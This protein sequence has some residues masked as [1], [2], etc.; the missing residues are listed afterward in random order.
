MKILKVR[1]I[2]IMSWMLR[3]A[4]ILS[5]L[6]WLFK[7]NVFRDFGSSVSSCGHHWWI[8]LIQICTSK[9]NYKVSRIFACFLLFY[10]IG[11]W[12]FSWKKF[13]EIKS[14]SASVFSN[15]NKVSRIFF[16]NR[17]LNFQ[18]K[19]IIQNKKEFC[20]LNCKQSFT[21]KSSKCKEFR[22]NVCKQIS[23]NFQL[24]NNFEFISEN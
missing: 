3:M 9:W 18:G 21:K 6:F 12:K 23:T 16:L 7:N 13:D 15:V 1:K 8:K 14:S 2:F 17:M 20:L 11:I 4:R 19:R 22:I 24:D 10:W 5:D